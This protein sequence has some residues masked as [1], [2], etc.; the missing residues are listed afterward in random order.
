M[1]KYV[2]ALLLSL[3]LVGTLSGTAAAQNGPV[4]TGVVANNGTLLAFWYQ[5]PASQLTGT[6]TIIHPGDTVQTDTIE[7]SIYSPN[8]GG[9]VTMSVEQYTLSPAFVSVRVNNTTVTQKVMQPTNIVWDNQTLTAPYRAVATDVLQLPVSN[10]VSNLRLNYDGAVI[11]FLHHTSPIVLPLPL[12]GGGVL[13]VFLGALVL[14][15]IVWMGGTATAVGIIRRA[16]YWPRLSNAQV[17]LIIFFAM[18]TFLFIIAPFFFSLGYLS[19]YWWL[20]PFY[21]VAVLVM[22]NLWPSMAYRWELLRIRGDE[23][24]SEMLTDRTEITVAKNGNGWERI[25]PYSYSKAI[26]RIFGV[27]TPLAFKGDGPVWYMRTGDEQTLSN[28]K[29]RKIS[30]IYLLPPL[31]EGISTGWSHIG[32]KGS[33]RIKHPGIVEQKCVIP[34]SGQHMRPVAAVFAGLINVSAVSTDREEIRQ[35][36]L[37][38]QAQLHAGAIR[39]EDT[40]LDI[41]T[42]EFLERGIRADRRIGDVSAAEGSSAAQSHN[43]GV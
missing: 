27:H 28:S 18:G 11:T 29:S 2:V 37:R 20:A 10:S 39:G 33:G 36:L 42:E 3:L 31:G 4:M 12:S 8:A 13:G 17:L 6:Y 41:Y 1:R 25:H 9:N 38:F 16:K 35:R 23:S 40:D 22:L 14:G 32:W 30:R 21:M 19:W 34:L 24:N 7:V 5:S 15:S 26:G 43:S